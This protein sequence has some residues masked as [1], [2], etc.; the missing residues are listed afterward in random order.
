LTGGQIFTMYCG[1]CHN[2]RILA[3]RPF[4]SY[5]NVAAHMH[6]RAN[7]TGKEYAELL[8]FLRRWADVADVPP[9]HPPEEPSPK[10]FIF[11]QPIPELRPEAATAE[12][13]APAKEPGAAARPAP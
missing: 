4:S 12:N 2:A 7:L 10:R 8:V 1:S 5:Q 3:D 9:P 11:S 13:A 6:T